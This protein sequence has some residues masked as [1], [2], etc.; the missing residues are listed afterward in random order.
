MR[1]EMRCRCTTK[2]I[3]WKSCY[4][5]S[6]NSQMS[7][8]GGNVTLRTSEG[9]LQLLCLREALMMWRRKSHHHI[10]KRNNF[11]VL[12]HSFLKRSTDQRYWLI[13]FSK[14]SCRPLICLG[15]PFVPASF[16]RLSSVSLPLA[17]CFP[18]PES[19]EAYRSL[20]SCLYS[21]F[22]RTSLATK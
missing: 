8:C 19:K 21:D 22:S 5:R 7:Q 10:T 15:S 16:R 9:H 14:Y 4:V 12:A 17:N 1:R 2:V 3:V 20:R 13:I 6:L 18:F 11:L